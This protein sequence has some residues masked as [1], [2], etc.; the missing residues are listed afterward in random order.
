MLNSDNAINS[1]LKFKSRQHLILCP[2]V[3][4][5]AAINVLGYVKLAALHLFDT[6]MSSIALSFS[7]TVSVYA[8]VCLCVSPS[9]S[10]Q[11]DQAAAKSLAGCC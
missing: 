1:E 6:L 5:R 9:I 7:V 8:C 2:F 3:C 10:M 11:P 4:S